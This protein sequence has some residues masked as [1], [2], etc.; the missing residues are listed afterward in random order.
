MVNQNQNMHMQFEEN[1]QVNSYK[2]ISNKLRIKMESLK[3][4]TFMMTQAY[5]LFYKHLTG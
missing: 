3:I 2:N 4:D 1:V 5:I